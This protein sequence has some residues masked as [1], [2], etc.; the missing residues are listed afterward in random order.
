M[1]ASQ[2]KGAQRV[3]DA[4]KAVLRDVEAAIE[5]AEASGDLAS[6]AE[7]KRIQ[8]AF[9]KSRIQFRNLKRG[10]AGLA[11]AHFIRDGT[12]ISLDSFQLSFDTAEVNDIF[13]NGSKAFT[14]A[15][16]T[17][18]YPPGLTGVKFLV[19]HE[20]RH[21]TTDNVFLPNGTERGHTDR[22][23][24]N[25]AIGTESDGFVRRFYNVP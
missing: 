23:G 4:V 12:G 3:V 1:S 13:A 6:V 10:T 8:R 24:H 9:L 7:L 2:A 5:V 21:A 16:Y 17:L 11:D 19:L 20:L 14:E 25:R 15:G 22:Y 18:D